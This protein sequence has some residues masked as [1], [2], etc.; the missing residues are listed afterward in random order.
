M[1]GEGLLPV[2]RLWRSGAGS[3][4]CCFR[5]V[6]DRTSADVVIQ[7]GERTLN[8]VIAHERLS[9]AIRPTHSRITPEPVAAVHRE[10]RRGDEHD[11][12]GVPT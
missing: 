1:R 9:V 4:P 7:V 10:Q 2:V 6:A 11:G 12:S 5:M 8:S 3:I